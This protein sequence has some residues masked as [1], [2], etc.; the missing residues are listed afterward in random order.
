MELTPA[1]IQEAREILGVGEWATIREI[2]S[3]YRALWQKCHP[4]TRNAANGQENE[5]FA[6][7]KRAYDILMQ[8]CENYVISFKEEKVRAQEYD[9]YKKFYDGWLGDLK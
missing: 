9:H 3:T 1:L 8:Y 5:R 2:K 7:L 4:D 6:E